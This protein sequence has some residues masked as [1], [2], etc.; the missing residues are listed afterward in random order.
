MAGYGNP[1]PVLK[2]YEEVRVRRNFVQEPDV[3]LYYINSGQGRG[4][5][6]VTGGSL[7]N[8]DSTSVGRRL[9]IGFYVRNNFR[10][11]EITRNRGGAYTLHTDGYLMDVLEP[12]YDED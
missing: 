12:T 7:L 6:E 3:I 11:F 9:T 4:D 1:E 8:E 5:F 10:S 2:Y